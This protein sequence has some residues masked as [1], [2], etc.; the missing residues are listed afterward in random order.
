[1]DYNYAFDLDKISEKDVG[2]RSN[3]ASEPL[4]AGVIAAI[5]DDC[6]S[7][8]IMPCGARPSRWPR[9]AGATWCMPIDTVSMGSEGDDAD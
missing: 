7:P 4:A 2:H 6:C 1:M 8:R 5:I 9:P 3:E